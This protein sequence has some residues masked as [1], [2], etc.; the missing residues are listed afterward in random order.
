MKRRILA[1]LGLLLVI[2]GFVLLALS[3]LLDINFII[4]VFLVLSA[5]V[6]LI[7]VKRMS[8][9]ETDDVCSDAEFCKNKTETK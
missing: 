7:I 2:A 9:E 5:F 4:P 1:M 8:P 3:M 6:V